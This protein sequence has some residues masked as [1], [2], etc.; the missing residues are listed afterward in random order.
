[1]NKAGA[2]SFLPKIQS[3]SELIQSQKSNSDEKSEE[4]KSGPSSIVL[5]QESQRQTNLKE[6]E[7]DLMESKCID[8]S[9]K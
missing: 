5:D 7:V 1:M 8:C 2:E 9:L 6:E 4:S 3:R